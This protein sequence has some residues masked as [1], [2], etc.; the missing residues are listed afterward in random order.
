MAFFFTVNYLSWGGI[1]M[2]HGK[3]NRLHPLDAAIC[4]MEEDMKK[5]R[6]LDGRIITSTSFYNFGV[7]KRS[8]LRFFR[9]INSTASDK[10]PV[11]K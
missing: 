8:L 1:E 7:L 6:Q 5:G 4:Q 3:V 11:K 10:H 9:S 2:A